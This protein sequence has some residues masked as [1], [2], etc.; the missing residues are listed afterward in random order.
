MPV[1]IIFVSKQAAVGVALTDEISFGVIIISRHVAELVGKL[2]E[3]VTL[4]IIHA[5]LAAIGCDLLYLVAAHVIFVGCKISKSI[6][7]STK[8]AAL[9]VK[10]ECFVSFGVNLF[11]R[12][13]Q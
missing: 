10:V 5:N 7:R 9:V 13:P 6:R 3:V 4:V 1:A 11:D 8:V 12:S 2:N